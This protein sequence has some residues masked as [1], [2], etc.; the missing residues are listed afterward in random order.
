MTPQHPRAEP[1]LNYAFPTFI[2]GKYRIPP[3]FKLWPEAFYPDLKAGSLPQTPPIPPAV[4]TGDLITAGHE[5][6]VTEAINDLWINEQW[7]ASNQLSDPTTAKGDIIVH[8]TGGITALPVGVDGTVLQ[9][10][11]TQP[12]GLK[13]NALNASSVGAVPTSRQVIAGT[14]MTGGGALTGDVTLNA[15]VTSV[16]GRTGAVVLTSADL[17]GANGVVTSGSYANPAWITSLDWSKIANV[18]SNLGAVSSVFGRTG[19]VVAAAGDYNASQITHAVDMTASYNDPAWITGLAWSKIVGAPAAGVSSVFGRSGAVVAASGDYHA[20][21]VTNA[22]DATQTYADP[23]WITS[24]S[25]G[26]ITGAPTIGS[27][28]TPWL[29][30]INAATWNLNN[31]GHIGVG[32]MPVYAVDVTGDVNI[33]GVYRVNG[34]P[35]S[36]GG[37]GQNQSPWLSNINAANYNLYS[38]GNLGVG[39]ASPQALIHA[40]AAASQNAVVL[41]QSD[42]GDQPIVK[43]VRGVYGT[44]QE[45]WEGPGANGA[46]DFNL[47]DKTHARNI[48]TVSASTG[49]FGLGVSTP[50]YALD[51]SGDVN[52]SGA[53]RINGVALPTVFFTDPTTTKADIITR[54]ASAITR[55]GVGADGQVL[56]ADST[57]TTGL[58]WAT[59]ATGGSQTP[60]TSAINAAYYPL[61]NVAAINFQDSSGSTYNT[62]QITCSDGANQIRLYAQRYLELQGG[63]GLDLCASGSP[64]TFSPSAGTEKMRLNASGQLGL[65]TQSPV[66]TLDV[67]LYNT[68]NST[69]RIGCMEF[70]SYALNNSWIADNLYYNGSWC[71]RATGTGAAIQ[72]MSGGIY[73]STAPSGSAGATAA[74]LII[75]LAVY[76]GTGNVDV[77]GCSRSMGWG[78]PPS[79]GAGVEVGYDGTAGRI[80]AYDR[81]AAAWKDLIINSM[82]ISA[83]GNV[84]LGIAPIYPLM[85]H[86]GSNLNFGVLLSGGAVALAAVN[87]AGSSNVPMSFSGSSFVFNV[88]NVGIGTGNP[89]YRLEVVGGYTVIG[90]FNTGSG[91][92]PASNPT[93]GLAVGW[94]Y[95]GG[96]AEAD[97]WN[98]FDSAAQSFS[99]KQKTGANS[100]VDLVTIMGNGNVGI[101]TTSPAYKLDVAG[102]CNITGTFRVNGT[103]LSTGGGS[104][105]GSAGYIQYNTGSAFGGSSS[106][107]WD[108]A[109]ARLGLWTTAPGYTIDVSFGDI[110]INANGFLRFGGRAGLNVSSGLAYNSARPAYSTSSIPG[111]IH[112]YSGSNGGLLRLSAGGSLLN[113]SWIDISGGSSVSDMSNTITFNSG[114]SERA[115]FANNGLLGINNNNPSYYLHLGTDSAGKPATNTWTIASDGRLK[116]NIRDLVGGL[117]I[118]NALHAVEAE[119]NGLGGM[120]AGQRVVGFLAEE[121]RDVL[122][123]TVGTFRAKLH[124]GDD[125]DTELLDFNLHEVLIHL[126]LAVQQ[127]AAERTLPT[128]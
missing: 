8:G 79:S 111:E 35:I 88:G 93:G 66:V 44:G 60:W 71:Y 31:V 51:V 113:A 19:V 96:P 110:N 48:V 63:W 6:I 124:A 37:G 75:G 120:R 82:T 69:A 41:I 125:Q 45:W 64:I 94:N 92:R 30:N 50:A 14:G 74:S 115:R 36:T 22:V 46:D 117:P 42:S 109:N 28:Q 80:S 39:T 116:Q 12:S 1:P 118:I 10:D 59:P 34:V 55:L 98:I 11:S 47:Y 99:F 43:Y 4:A 20:N 40:A 65:G 76:S 119:Y 84:G 112:D 54:N 101:G 15:N 26:K 7:L 106:L 9:A 72:L 61:N 21:Q 25:Y 100:H 38:V 27:M 58:K 17:T 85:V 95:N 89:N 97:F 126:I 77:A 107:F 81:T 53:F 122:P 62:G 3:D 87:D 128:H 5:N 86:L 29:Q 16:F 105:A 33:T 68:T 127:L 104:P 52:C 90:E 24:L 67:P 83:N 121:I 78:T 2:P 73:L 91:I 23:A 103:P 57:Q 56:T 114:G 70:N 102:D 18:P 108:I 123:H 49:R 13:W 32:M